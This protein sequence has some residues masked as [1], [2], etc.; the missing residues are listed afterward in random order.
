MI[1]R[2]AEKAL[3]AAHAVREIESGM[4]V[5]LGTG[6]TASCAIRE[7]GALIAAGLRVEAVA[8]SEAS[9]AL[10][11]SVGIP[12]ISLERV[13]RVDVAID[14]VD[15]IDPA[16]NAIKGKGGALLREKIVASASA[17][18]IAIADSSK[19]VPRL[20]RRA[21]PVEVLTFASAWVERALRELG[22]ASERRRRSD[23]AP[24]LTD[25]GNFVLDLPVGV[26]ADPASLAAALE[27]VP[28]I[29]GHGLFLAE[30]DTAY[31]ARGDEVERLDRAD[32]RPPMP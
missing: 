5:G 25:Q 22:F 18:M 10:A 12:L 30:I 20:G 16:L 11:R 28:G 13:S 1:D 24:F 19:K 23:G 32:P 8:T 2:E 4:L 7:L 6:S 17:R 31:I 26:I 29:V 9:V 21:L 15:Q 14:G 3:A 27:K